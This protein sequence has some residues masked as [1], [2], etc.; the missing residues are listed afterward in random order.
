MACSCEEV[1]K[2]WYGGCG[3]IDTIA[4]CTGCL[5]I[6]SGVSEEIANIGIRIIVKTTSTI[7]IGVK[8]LKGR[9][10]SPVS[11]GAERGQ[12]IGRSDITKRW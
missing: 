12:D 2:A 11:R 1:R 5:C 3:T 9:L 10:K 6:F 7:R 4:G 8:I